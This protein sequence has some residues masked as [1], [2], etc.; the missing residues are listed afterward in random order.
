MATEEAAPAKEILRGK[1]RPSSSSA[2]N[3][4][5]QGIG[6]GTEPGFSPALFFFALHRRGTRL[7]FDC[8]IHQRRF[9]YEQ[10][11]S[12]DAGLVAGNRCRVC[13]IAATVASANVA[14][15]QDPIKILG[16]NSQPANWT[17]AEPDPARAHAKSMV[18]QGNVKR[19]RH[20]HVMINTW[21]KRE[22]MDNERS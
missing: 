4:C 19:T 22:S 20:R 2:S 14:K 21:K 7:V 11:R 1:G 10:G 18:E 12:A 8:G 5:N 17:A 6:R 16:S 13:V 9:I 3:F 15:A